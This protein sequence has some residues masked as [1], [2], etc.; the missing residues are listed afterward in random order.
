MPALPRFLYHPVAG[1]RGPRGS[2]RIHTDTV[3]V[4]QTPA[5]VSRQ[6]DQRGSQQRQ[7]Q[8]PTLHAL[9]RAG[10]AQQPVQRSQRQHHYG[11]DGVAPGGDLAPDAADREQV[12]QSRHAG[13]PAAEGADACQPETGARPEWVGQQ[14]I[15][16]VGGHQTEQRGHR[17]VDHHRMQWMPGNGRTTD[18]NFLNFGHPGLPEQVDDEV[19]RERHWLTPCFKL[20][21]LTLA[22]PFLVACEG[23][24]SALDPAGPMAREVA[25]LWWAMCAFATLVLVVVTVLWVHAMRRQR[26]QMDEARARQLTLRWLIGG[27]LLLPTLSIVVLL[28][29]GIPIGHRMLPLPLNGEQPLRIEVIGHQWWWEVRYPDSGVVTANQ[30]HLPVGRPVDLD[31]TSA[32]VIHSFWVPRLGGKIDMIPGRHNRIRLQ[33]DA[34]GTFRGQC[35]EFCGTQHTHMILDVQAH[36]EEDFANWLQARSD[37]QANA[38]LGSAGETFAA[39]CGQCHRV[40]GVSDGARAPDLSDIG[41]RS[42]LGAGVL[43][44]EPGALHRWL[45]EHQRLK[46]GNAMPLHDDLDPDHLSA[47]ADWLETLRP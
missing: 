2:A 44:N 5:Q 19:K 26:P 18:D 31:V 8:P 3:F 38:L 30:L 17:K 32:D 15:G 21:T 42:M 34:P 45:Q 6:T 13:D 28:L 37:W 35:S 40:A 16:D 9:L 20:T 12:D 46:P 29:F 39:R 14:Q 43:S 7:I 4:H 33:A 1:E 36:E 22:V 41:A 27:G 47:I 23:P 25:I 24:Q 10:V 11:D